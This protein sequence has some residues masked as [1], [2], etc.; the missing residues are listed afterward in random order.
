MARRWEEGSFRIVAGSARSGTTWLLDAL[1]TANSLRTVFEPLHPEGVSEARP[2]A[3]RYLR[4]HTQEPALEDLLQRALAGR[5]WG[6][7][8]TCRVRPDQL[9]LWDY[10]QATLYR[11]WGLLSRSRRAWRTRD[12]P[13]VV[14]FIRANL[15]LGWIRKH[16]GARTVLL[17]R[18]PGAVVASRLSLNPAA[19]RPPEEVLR[20]YFSDPALVED[21]LKPVRGLLERRLSPAELHGALWCIENVVP[22]RQASEYEI[23]VVYYERLVL[24]C[25]SEWSRT[26][27]SLGLSCRPDGRLLT[28]P[29][30]QVSEEMKRQRFDPTKLARWMEKLESGDQIRIGTILEQFG[31]GNYRMEDPM[32]RCRL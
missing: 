22:L 26:L 19:W 25:E 12:R 29:S 27:R 2:F 24:G 30:Q 31:I 1:A 20:F 11:L 3:N 28:R 6:M 13:P 9:K 5:I 4:P 18:H 8:P 14:K 15:M 7:W 23:E 10:P 17:L 32:P 16:L 21:Y